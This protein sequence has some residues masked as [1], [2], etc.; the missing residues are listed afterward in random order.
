MYYLLRNN[1]S[2]IPD[3]VLKK[4]MKIIEANSESI[5]EAWTEHFDE[6]R[7]YC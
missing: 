1:N 4:I 7:Y 5:I 2:K 6:I 3:R